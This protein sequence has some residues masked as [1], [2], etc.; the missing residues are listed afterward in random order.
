MPP[1]T[2]GM[3]GT[4]S[5]DQNVFYWDAY[6]MPISFMGVSLG[7]LGAASVCMPTPPPFVT[8]DMHMMMT[9]G[10]PGQSYD[11]YQWELTEASV[12]EAVNYI[13]QLTIGPQWSAPDFPPPYAP[14]ITEQGKFKPAILKTAEGPMRK[15]G[16]VPQSFI[17]VDKNGYL[18][19]CLQT[20]IRG[21]DKDIYKGWAF[22]LDKMHEIWAT[23][24]Y[25]E[26][27]PHLTLGAGHWVQVGGYWDGYEF[28]YTDISNEVM[29]A[30]PE[31]FVLGGGPTLLDFLTIPPVNDGEW[32]HLLFSFDIS[33]SVNLERPSRPPGAGGPMPAPIIST[34]C[35]AWIALDDKN[36]N[37]GPLQHRFPMHDGI[38]LPLLPGMGTD[39]VG[40][41]PVTSALRST[42]DLEANG[43]LPR[44]C[45]ILPTRGNPK[46]QLLRFVSSSG[47]WNQ[48]ST[49]YIS[50]GDYNFF[51]WT[52]NIWPLFHHG[53]WKGSLDPPR[54]STPDPATFDHPTYNCSGF[55]IPIAGYPI[56]IPA[57]AHHIDHNTGIEMAELQIWIGR[58]LDTGLETNRRL[59]IAPDKE[60]NAKKPVPPDIAAKTLGRPHVLL[61]GNHNWIEGINTGSTGS[62]DGSSDKD[63]L[64]PTGRFEP[65]AGI[66]KFKPEP[67]LGK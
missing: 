54:P 12:I 19:I 65:V 60:T 14:Y 49:Q 50:K 29:G 15:S 40:F 23:L 43:I 63:K 53:D 51:R 17:G 39:V 11:Y 44:N 32:H 38:S 6:G 41:G 33:G 31:Y 30:G 37:G 36:Y 18:T 26:A 34:T 9:F 64:I 56:G 24:S 5:Y 27:P 55:K 47:T 25:Y 35:R 10:M 4:G 16:Y 48:E 61:H 45:W 1:D 57:S 66:E 62:T 52:G 8:N 21:K 2:V 46:D 13:P 67:E 59:F 20:N 7:L 22:Q 3:I 58:T 28:E 42:L